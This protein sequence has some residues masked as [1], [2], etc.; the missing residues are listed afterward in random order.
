MTNSNGKQLKM[1]ISSLDSL[2][3]VKLLKYETKTTN[4]F[5]EPLFNFVFFCNV[6]FD[7]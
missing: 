3:R 1:H 5:S 7:L 2:L 6:T 4:P